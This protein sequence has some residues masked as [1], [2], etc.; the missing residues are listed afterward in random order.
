M[1]GVNS[2]ANS[3]VENFVLAMTSA[4]ELGKVPPEQKLANP[5]LADHSTIR[6]RLLT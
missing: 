3:A 5:N 4:E 1:Y 6:N 2:M